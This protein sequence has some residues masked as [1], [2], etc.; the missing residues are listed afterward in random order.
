M[1]KGRAPAGTPFPFV[2]FSVISD[3]QA[4]TFKDKFDD[5]LIQFSLFSSSSSTTE[6]E[7][8]YD[9]LKTLYDDCSLTPTGATVCLMKRENSHFI[10]E[11]GPNPDAGDT[12]WH[13]AV[14]YGIIQ[15]RN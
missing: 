11:D 12:I 7:D 4:D 5:V 14:E 6:I 2:V 10:V 3:I 1:F 15:Q 8:M 9:H 13:Y